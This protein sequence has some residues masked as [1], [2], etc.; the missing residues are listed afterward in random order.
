MPPVSN[1]SAPSSPHLILRWPGMETNQAGTFK[2]TNKLFIEVNGVLVTPPEGTP[3]GYPFETAVP[4]SSPDVRIESWIANPVLKK[5]PS[6]ETFYNSLNVFDLNLDPGQ[7]YNFEFT[8]KGAFYRTNKFGFQLSDMHGN[9]IYELGGNV[10][11]TSQI[12]SMFL[13][14]VGLYYLSQPEVKNDK[15]YRNSINLAILMGLT[16]WILAILSIFVF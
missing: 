9:L 16:L 12:V 7:S 4:I 11:K 3:Y 15:L 1:P 8:D 13:P 5:K 6:K 10:N 2:K 14:P